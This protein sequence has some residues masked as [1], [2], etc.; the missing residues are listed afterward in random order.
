MNYLSS[1]P[2]SQQLINKENRLLSAMEDI[3][4]QYLH[5]VKRIITKADKKDPEFVFYDVFESK[6]SV[7]SV[8]PALFDLILAIGI[9]FYLCIV[10]IFV[11]N[12]T[13]LT[14]LLPTLK[15]QKTY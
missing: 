10:Y 1:Q 3:L 5:E 8:K 11:E 9:A 2:R 6:M 4:I 15:K 7:Y 13:V 12:F 14:A